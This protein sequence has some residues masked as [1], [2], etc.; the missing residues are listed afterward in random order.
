MRSRS[1]AAAIVAGTFVLGLAACSSNPV[2][3]LTERAVEQQVEAAT[4]AEIDVDTGGSGASLPKGFPT[5]LPV[6][7]A[8]LTTAISVAD[9][10]QLGYFDVAESE[11]DALVAAYEQDPDYTTEGAGDY[12]DFATWSFSGSRYR[13][14]VAVV[15]SDGNPQ[16]SYTVSRVVES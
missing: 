16:L 11:V 2:E 1:V 5:E 13:A 3:G 15:M 8:K 12:G 14:V 9:G 10:W 4:G 7:D 6:P